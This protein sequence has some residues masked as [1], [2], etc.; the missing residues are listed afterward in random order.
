MKRLLSVFFLM[1]SMP[2]L[3]ASAAQ[4][5]VGIIGGVDLPI[6]Q[7][8][9]GNGSVFGFKGKVSLIPGV[10]LEP[11]VNFTRLEAG[12]SFGA[13]PGSKITSLG[14]DALLGAGMGS[15][16]LRMYGILGAGYYS[17]TRGHDEDAGEFGWTTGLGCEL[18]LIS[19]TGF[20]IRGELD[21]ISSEDGGTRKSAA[22]VGGLNYYLEY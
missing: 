18:G 19:N 22:I 9:Q 6:A 15:Q 5:G 21:V 14:I 4:T 13:R 10:V 17:I 1:I 20:E 7:E 11:N 8:D 16:G 2:P 12:Y 3:S